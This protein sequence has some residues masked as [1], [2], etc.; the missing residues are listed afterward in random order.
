MPIPP[1]DAVAAFLSEEAAKP[2]GPAPCAMLV[3]RWI[4]Q[5]RGFSPIARFGR[6]LETVADV[7]GFLAAPGGLA[8]AACRVLHGAGLTRIKP[9]EAEQGDVALIVD[10]TRRYLAI[11]S[12]R[13]W[14][15]RSE[16]GFFT[17]TSDAVVRFVWRV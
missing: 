7:D 3:D 8:S 10:Q 13:Y 15:S 14:I 5:R 17:A 9:A 16:A 11:Q 2:G 1:P 4:E 12:D 6:P